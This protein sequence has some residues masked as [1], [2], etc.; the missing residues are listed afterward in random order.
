VAEKK[1]SRKRLIAKITL[2]CIAVL[3]IGAFFYAVYD[4][5]R[6]K[7][8]V[9]PPQERWVVTEAHFE[10]E[11]APAYT[12]T[13]FTL[14]YV[15]ENRVTWVDINAVSDDGWS[16]GIDYNRSF[17]KGDTLKC[18]GVGYVTHVQIFFTSDYNSDG[19]T[20]VLGVLPPKS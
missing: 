9:L 13:N 2:A 19:D 15:G 6:V 14:K 20:I 10:T 5:L 7:T 17:F 8:E 11:L 3:I 1:P 12:Q 18:I 16:T 4:S